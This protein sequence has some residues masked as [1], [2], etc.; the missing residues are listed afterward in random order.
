MLCPLYISIR[1]FR[2]GDYMFI[3]GAVSGIMII[4]AFFELVEVLKV[5]LSKPIQL[6]QKQSKLL[7]AKGLDF[8]VKRNLAP[9]PKVF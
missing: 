9:K 2:N 8:E 4:F 1:F 3:F 5:F 6:S 7:G